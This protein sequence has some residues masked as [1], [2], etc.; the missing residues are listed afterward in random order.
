MAKFKGRRRRREKPEFDQELIDIARVTRIVAGGRRMR[1]RATVVIGDRKRRVGVGVAKG[2][3]VSMAI[4]KAVTKA[5]KEMITVPITENGTIPHQITVKSGSARLFLKPAFPGTGIIA[6]GAV[7]PV[8]ELAGVKNVFGKIYGT[9][10]KLNNA[11]VTIKALLGLRK[12]EEIFLGRGVE[13]KKKDKA[14]EEKVKKEEGKGNVKVE[15]SDK[16]VTKK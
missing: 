4:E 11:T 9:S 2:N 1:F 13:F 5:K 8:M 16:K 7:R 6:G 12:G 3:D 14:V 10:N 15:K